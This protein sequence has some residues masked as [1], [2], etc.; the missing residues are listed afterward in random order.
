M[1]SLESGS[2]S[3]SRSGKTTAPRKE[4]VP[5]HTETPLQAT[6]L[7]D[8]VSGLARVLPTRMKELLMARAE[9]KL[10]VEYERTYYEALD[11]P[12]RITLDRDLVFWSQEGKL[13]PSRRFAV[14]VPGL[15]ILEGKAPLGQEDGIRRLL[16]PLEPWV[17]RSSKYVIACQYLGLLPG[18][19]FGPI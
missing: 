3:K 12:L 17:T 8:I 2:S 13:Y 16:H 6:A 15:T 14:R 9:P 11:G 10:M 5:I 1:R 7:H 19:Y 4:R 18:S